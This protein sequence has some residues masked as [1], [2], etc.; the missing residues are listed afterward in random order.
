MEKKRKFSSVSRSST[1]YFTEACRRRRLTLSSFR[2]KALYL[3]NTRAWRSGP[4]PD[5]LRRGLVFCILARSPEYIGFSEHTIITY[6]TILISTSPVFPTCLYKQ[7]KDTGSF[8]TAVS[9]NNTHLTVLY[10]LPRLTTIKTRSLLRLRLLRLPHPH[11][12]RPT[13]SQLWPRRRCR[14]SRSRTRSRRSRD[15]RFPARQVSGFGLCE[16]IGFESCCGGGVRI[17]F[18]LSCG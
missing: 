6:S 12:R 9:S 18:V 5:S 10:F 17:E 1:Q 11:P 8:S 3:T 16:E 13:A 14:P 2:L 15:F 4:L 7:W